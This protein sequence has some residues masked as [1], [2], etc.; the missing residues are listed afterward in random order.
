M[1]N[2]VSV[3]RLMRHLCG[4]LSFQHPITSRDR[5]KYGAGIHVLASLSQTKTCVLNSHK[6]P[7]W[8]HGQCDVA[9][10]LFI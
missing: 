8:L 6:Y 2:K 1:T 10:I 7:P 9:S 5:A 4:G 3:R